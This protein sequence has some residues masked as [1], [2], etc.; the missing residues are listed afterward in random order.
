MKNSSSPREFQIRCA[1]KGCSKRLVKTVHNRKYCSVCVK[2]R[3]PKQLESDKLR[4]HKRRR[5]GM[6]TWCGK[7]QSISGQNGCKVC[8][9]KQNMWSRMGQLNLPK[10]EKLRAR[11]ALEKAKKC[12]CCGS[13]N[14]GSRYDWHIDHSHKQRI[15]RGILCFY[16]NLMLGLAK[17]D[18]RRLRKAIRY[19][20]KFCS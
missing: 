10:K 2:I 11:I 6:C 15:F 20:K 13:K 17:E 16:C 1:A 18:I 14:T 19:L 12:D 7:R 4:Y 9:K 3:S 8:K 5:I